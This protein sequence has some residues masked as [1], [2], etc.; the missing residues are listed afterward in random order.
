MKVQCSAKKRWEQLFLASVYNPLE[1][2]EHLHK[3]KCKASVY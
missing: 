3:E 2:T 1:K